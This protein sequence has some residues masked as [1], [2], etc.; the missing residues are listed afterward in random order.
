MNAL[1]GFIRRRF[2][3]ERKPSRSMCTQGKFLRARSFG[4]VLVTLAAFV[5]S[6]ASQTLVAQSRFADSNSRERSTTFGT[7][8]GWQNASSWA[9][10]IDT[11][12]QQDWKLGVTAD[13]TETGV[14]IRQ[15]TPGSAANRARLEVSDVIIAVGGYQVGLI[16]G[17]LFDL[18]EELR[19][20]AD[21]QGNVTL[22]VQDHRNGLLASVRV[23]LDGNQNT[24]R[25]DLIYRERLALPSDAV[26]NVVLE[27]LTRP[28]YTVRNGQVAFRASNQPLIP[29]EILYDPNYI[30]PQDTYQVRATVTSGGRTIL[31][32]R[33]PARVLTQG[34][35]S[36]V[37]LALSPINQTPSFPT[38]SSL[39][40]TNSPVITAGYPNMNFVQD[41]LVQVY[42]QYLGRDPWPSE[43]AA[44]ALTPGS[45]SRISNVPIEIMG[46]QE[47]YDK[48]GLSDQK[49]FTQVFQNILGRAPSAQEL[50]LWMRRFT[51]LRESRTELLRQLYSQVRR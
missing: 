15:I 41:Q 8:P 12:Q 23:P 25:G 48:V 51:D 28:F 10:G 2:G 35:P 24:L 42:R 33:Q 45:A 32:T 13:N 44:W 11:P 38:N 9:G 36:Q 31:E 16:D 47:Y 18:G 34:N 6:T 29:F 3:I 7:A 50:D 22:L 30:Q 40:A 43:L 5:C 19:R 4:L 37:Q 46:S 27:N 17:G 1:A 14:V 21:N 20:R 49:W 26:V 39:V